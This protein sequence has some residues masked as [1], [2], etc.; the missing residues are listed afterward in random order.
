LFKNILKFLAGIY[1][2]IVDVSKEEPYVEEIEKLLL[3][4]DKTLESFMVRNLDVDQSKFNFPHFLSRT[5][6]N[7]KDFPM[8][9]GQLKNH[10]Q[11]RAKK[12]ISAQNRLHRVN[13]NRLV[14][15]F[16]QLR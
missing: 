6:W 5:N 4:N 9:K 8:R 16:G 2:V 10:R 12:R 1:R 3:A 15:F 14:N 7:I 13:G 11:R